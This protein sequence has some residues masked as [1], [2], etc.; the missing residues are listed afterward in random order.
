MAPPEAKRRLLERRVVCS[1]RQGN[2]RFSPHFYVTKGE[3]EALDKILE[4]TGL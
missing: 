1:V 2:V 3:L 4:K